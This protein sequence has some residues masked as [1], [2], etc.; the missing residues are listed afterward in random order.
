MKN[1]QLI[2]INLLKTL[3]MISILI[4]HVN[5]KITPGGFIGVDLFFVISGYLLAHTLIKYRDESL[6]EILKNRIKKLWLPLFVLIFCVMIYITLFNKKILDNSHLDGVSGL[7]FMSNWSLIFNNI[8]YFERFL[9]N[10]FK[11]LWYISV[12]FQSTILITI[13]F[14]GFIQINIKKYN[15]F[16]V[17][18]LGIGLTSFILQQA[19]LDSNNLSRVYYGTDTRIYAIIIG[20]LGYFIYP[21]DKLQEKRKTKEVLRI[22]LVSFISL[23]LFIFL[24]LSISEVD[25]WI[26][27]IG[28]LL[29]AINSLVLIITVGSTNNI[30]SKLFSKLEILLFPGKYSY[31]IYLWHY[32]IIVLSQTIGEL[33]KPNTIYSIIRVII[34]FIIAFISYKYLEESKQRQNRKK[35]IKN[36]GTKLNLMFQ[37]GKYVIIPLLGIFIMGSFGY[38]MPFL[39]TAF[40]DNT[41]E[42]KIGNELVVDPKESKNESIKESI[43]KKDTIDETKNEKPNKPEETINYSNP[44]KI[45]YDKLVLIGDSTGVNVGSALGELYPNTTIDTKVSRQLS[46]STD[47]PK[48]YANYDDKNTAVIFMLGSNG[49]FNETHLEEL[50]QPFPNSKKIFINVKIPDPWE[51]RVNQTLSSFAAKRGD[52]VLVDWYSVALNKP[53]YLASD[54]THLMKPGVARLVN[55]IITELQK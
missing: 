5:I 25:F 54:A 16:I 22:N 19:L 49:I 52:I 55:M 46:K 47:I 27:R 53:E 10:P 11:H 33:A 37:S 36:R 7:F 13:L 20:V 30:I 48:K 42:V 24:M 51:A 31:G 14:K 9:I 34:T 21:I 26:Y 18:M 23:S 4:Y 15:M 43:D 50:V 2:G 6:W 29:F 8:S 28:F 41:R 40:I 44:P 39:S 17:L 3:A 12:L 32:P 38:S 45:K 1:R 35:R